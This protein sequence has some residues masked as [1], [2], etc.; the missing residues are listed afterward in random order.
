M[1][2]SAVHRIQKCLYFT[3]QNLL[4]IGRS[5]R[6]KLPPLFLSEYQNKD[7]VF[8]IGNWGGDCQTFLF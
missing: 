2:R 1:K 6:L 8:Q 4:N 3:R 5:Y 7:G